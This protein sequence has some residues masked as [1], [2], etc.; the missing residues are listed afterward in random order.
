MHVGQ[1]D[2]TLY[3]A[4]G[5]LVSDSPPERVF[6]DREDWVLECQRRGLR[7]PYTVHGSPRQEQFVSRGGGTAALWNVGRSRGV[8]FESREDPKPRSDSPVPSREEEQQAVTARIDEVLTQQLGYRCCFAVVWV[9]AATAPTL[10]G[11]AANVSQTDAIQLLQ[12]MIDRLEG[13]S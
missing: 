6:W 8:V 11:Y 4:P 10:A 5:V 9:K 12:G 7:G 13:V 3:R 2:S 1:G